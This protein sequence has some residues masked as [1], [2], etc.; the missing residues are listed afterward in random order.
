MPRILI[1]FSLI[2]ITAAYLLR[3]WF[4]KRILLLIS[5]QPIR[6]QADRWWECFGEKWQPTSPVNAQQLGVLLHKIALADWQ[7]RNAKQF[8]T[9]LQMR[10][11]FAVAP[12]L[13]FMVAILAFFAA[14]IPPVAGISIVALTTGITTFAS[15]FRIPTELSAISLALKKMREE[16]LIVRAEDEQQIAKAAIATVWLNAFPP[17][18]GK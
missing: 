11:L 4:A 1:I 10:R 8:A 13:S 16:R 6:L 15:I 12:P 14:K 5:S 17:I 18:L 9:H 2:L 3:W 7:S